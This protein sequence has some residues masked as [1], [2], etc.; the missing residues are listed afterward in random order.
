M[1]YLA[2]TDRKLLKILYVT[3]QSATNKGETLTVVLN[4]SNAF[5]MVCDKVLLSKLPS[6]TFYPSL[7]TFTSDYL[8][9]HF[10]SALVCGQCSLPEAIKSGISQDSIQSLTLFLSINDH[11]C[12]SSPTQS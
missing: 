7:Y 5:V 8:S 1:Q 4:V 6:F 10:I 3:K 9:G 11:C 12:I 2:K